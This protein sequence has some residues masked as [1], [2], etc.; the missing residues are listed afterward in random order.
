MG[1]ALL[2]DLIQRFARRGIYA[3][4]VNTQ[5]TNM[6]SRHLYERFEFQPTGY[7][8]PVWTTNL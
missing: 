2:S 6:R 8:L 3:L 1:R 4:T 5:S 7:N